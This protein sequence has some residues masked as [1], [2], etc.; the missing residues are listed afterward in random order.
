MSKSI[1]HLKYSE[2][3]V[4]N[5][6]MDNSVQGTECKIAVISNIITSQLKEILECSLRLEGINAHVD[7]G[8]YDNVVQDSQRFAD[9]SMNLIF[10]EAANLV[11]G[12]QYKAN[13]MDDSTLEMLIGKVKSEIDLVF[14]NLEESSLV[15]LNR[16]SSMTFNYA[17]LNRDVFDEICDELNIYVKG[18]AP[19]NTKIVDIDRV[20]SRVSVSKSIDLRYYYSSKALYT[21]EFFKEYSEYIKPVL[22]SA[23]GRAKKALIFDCDN[24]LWKGVLGEDGAENLEMSSHS[25]Y[26]V[27]FEEVQCLAKDL[28]NMGVILGLCSKNNPQDVDDVLMS[29]P[30]MV[31]KDDDL[32][33]K[34][35]NWD[36]KLS[37]IEDISRS[38]NIGLDSLVFVDDSDFEVNYIREGLLDVVVL[39]VP[40]RLHEYPVMMREAFDRFYQMSSASED[41]RKTLMYKAQQHREGHRHGF[42]SLVEYLE[43]LELKIK[44]H[45]ND[46][47]IIPRQAQMTQKTNQFNLTTKR[48][49]ESDISRFIESDRY[50]VFAF[51]ASDKFGGYGLAGLAILGIE[52]DKWRADIDTFLMSCRVIGR[53]IEYAFFDFILAHLKKLDIHTIHATFRPTA[54][55]S[56]VEGFYD[57]LGF[58]L[59]DSNDKEKKYIINVDEYMKQVHH[60]IE[61]R[62]ATEN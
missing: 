4:L 12:L 8:D 3:L 56:Q 1:K 34:R 41:A 19:S 35:V 2:I 49:T 13:L 5:N 38:L 14:S 62:D 16:F 44:V 22:L 10:W 21:V 46:S 9:T 30:D 42:G 17:R 6:E 54:K 55:N 57:D 7:L 33:I 29:H 48:Y 26:G 45:I 59:I 24:T 37:N 43:S 47:S 50:M 53:N 51:D 28:K 61:V 32:A 39:Q 27:V 58:K 25:G 36:D 31:L 20:I 23:L 60:F 18:N 52:R 40:S 11:D 15:I